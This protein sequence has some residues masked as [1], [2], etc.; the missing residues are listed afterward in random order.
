MET[1]NPD[2][3]PFENVPSG[4]SS[5][6]KVDVASPPSPEQ[7]PSNE[8]SVDAQPVSPT[9][10]R[11]F[12][13]HGSH[14]Q[15]PGFSKTEFCCA[16]DQTLHSGDELEL[17]IT[18][19]Q[20][21]SINSSNPYITY[22]IKT[23]HRETHHRYSEFES[24]RANLAK[25]Y[26]TLIIPPIP[27]KQ[28]IGDYAV[29][30]AKAREDA[31]MIARRKRMLQT[32]LNRIA[33]HPILSNDHV[34]HRFLDGEVSWTE[35]LHSP[36]LSLLPK[37]IL[38]APSHN[39]TDQSASP[40]YQALPNP[41]AAHPLRN[42][43]QKFLD[44]E[45]FTNKFSTHL[46]GPMEKVT[47]RTLKRWTEHAQDQSDLGAALNGFSLNESGP[48]AASIE[49][50]GQAADAGYLS[51][52]KLLQDME[53]NWGE[54]LHEYAQ[55]ATI[56]KRLLAYRHQKHVQFEMTQESLDSK[57]GQLEDLE[58]SEREANRLASALTRGRP[59]SS[60][61][62]SVEAEGGDATGDTQ[63][64]SS[65]PPHPG[66]NPA[67]RRTRPPGSGLLNA[68]SYTLHGMM[69]VD[70]ET[71]RRNNITKLRENI[72]QLEDALHL[73]AQD[74]KYSSSTIQADLDRFQRQKVADLRQMAIGL[75]QTHRDWCRRNLEAWEDAKKEIE[76]IP[77]HPNQL[78]SSI[79]TTVVD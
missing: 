53:Q 6:F 31:A 58:S 14:K 16:C 8:A 40:A 35:I 42:P 21:T 74:L 68:L 27:D 47:R 29:K 12:P 43:N 76:K 7:Q 71:A 51:T 78:A 79:P 65:V 4:A 20:K 77:D 24:L 41:S 63:S 34:F 28:T 19:A 44:S 56:I 11:P 62:T 66:S 61:P 17:L 39:P 38:K 67:R 1:Y 5:A 54:P 75:A 48:L 37:N 64:P 70:P 73:C 30:Q 55:F 2:Q 57:R 72:S 18:D 9:L 60:D 22:I 10:E 59:E 45:S 3:N 32:F 52:T 46:G 49:K 26:P 15:S 13:S 69:D 25:L 36:P 33:K 23:G 50:V